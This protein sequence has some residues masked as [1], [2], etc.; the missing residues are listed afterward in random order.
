MI[1]TSRYE[2][3]TTIA[4]EASEDKARAAEKRLTHNILGQLV[5]VEELL[6]DGRYATTRYEYDGAGQMAHIRDPGCFVE[7]EACV[8]TRLVHDSV[9]RGSASKQAARFGAMNTTRTTTSRRSPIH[10]RMAKRIITPPVWSTI[11]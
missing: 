9:G 4:S 10:I 1:A 7:G 5:Q 6:D 2:G 8:E 3:L 11:F